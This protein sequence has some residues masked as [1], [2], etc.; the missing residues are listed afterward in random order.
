MI[1]KHVLYVIII[2]IVFLL[3][4][5]SIWQ[6]L[7]VIGLTEKTVQ[8]SAPID[9]AQLER[10]VEIWQT[11]E[12]FTWEGSEKRATSEASES[13]TIQTA[14]VAVRNGSGISGAASEIADALEDID[15]ISIEEVGNTQQSE[16]TTLTYKRTV[17]TSILTDIRTVLSKSYNNISESTLPATDEFDVIVTLGIK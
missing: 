11:R 8:K 12:E 10:A 13:A 14:L 1:S 6:F 15:H 9:Y 2:G 17:A 7:S 16:E 3:A 4:V 5:S